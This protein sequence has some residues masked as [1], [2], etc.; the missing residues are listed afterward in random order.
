MRPRYHTAFLCIVVSLVV[1]HAFGQAEP[2]SFERE[3]LPLLEK[4]CNECHHPHKTNSGLDLTQLSTM[5]RG[6]S[7]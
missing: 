5:L 6:V 7:T 3:V 4:H 2:V 1:E